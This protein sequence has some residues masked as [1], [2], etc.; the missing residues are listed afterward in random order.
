MKLT[1]VQ[2]VNTDQLSVVKTTMVKTLTVRQDTH[3]LSLHGAAD[4]VTM[5]RGGNASLNVVKEKS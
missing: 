3:A 5:S 4:S 2:T 1:M